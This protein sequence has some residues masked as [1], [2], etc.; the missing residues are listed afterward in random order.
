V[1]D[2]PQKLRSDLLRATATAAH[3]HLAHSHVARAAAALAQEPFSPRAKRDLQEALRR[4]PIRTETFF[5][6][7]E[8]LPQC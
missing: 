7:Q 4:Y 2:E 8:G 5:D 1:T 6:A 3:W